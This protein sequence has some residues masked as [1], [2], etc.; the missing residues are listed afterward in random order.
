[1]NDKMRCQLAQL[2]H[3]A[4]LPGLV[5]ECLG[6]SVYPQDHEIALAGTGESA[7]HVAREAQAREE[8]DECPEL[9]RA[10]P[11]LGVRA[12][13]APR[14]LPN[15]LDA[16]AMGALLE[17]PS[18]A[19]LAARDRALLELAYSSALRVSEL[20]AL[21]WHDVDLDEGLVRVL[22]KGGKTRVVPVGAAAR[23]ALAAWRTQSAP[24]AR[25]APLFP[26]RG[27]RTLLTS[28]TAARSSGCCPRRATRLA[29]R[30][31]CSR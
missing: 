31:Q 18:D 3:V 9:A 30:R 11:A 20:V 5:E 24:A 22:G 8:Q 13:K 26:G 14:K 21:R 4:R 2:F 16:D 6:W 25:D 15:V 1:L 17:L 28:R 12:P 19:P 7:C 27:G 23:T 29:P 10:N